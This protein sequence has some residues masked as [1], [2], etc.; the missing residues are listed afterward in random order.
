MNMLRADV[1]LGREWLHGLGPSLKRSYEHNTIAF[2]DHGVHVLLI[3]ERDIPP[4]P[5]ICTTE[6]QYLSKNNL[7]EK[8]F[9]CYNLSPLSLFSRLSFLNAAQ[10]SI[11]KFNEYSVF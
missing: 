3:G 4:S 2:D 11:G 6:L 8:M 1:L 5:L 10:N 9:F 7:I